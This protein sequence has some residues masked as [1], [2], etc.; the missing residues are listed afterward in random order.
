[1]KKKH[2]RKM[3]DYVKRELFDGMLDPPRLFF[4]SP[5]QTTYPFAIDGYCEHNEGHFTIGVTKGLTKN[6]TFDTIVHEMIH[7]HLIETKHYEGHGKPFKKMCR[8]A[9]DTFYYNML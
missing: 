7:Q 3:F 8:K 6:E 9:I 2:L 1:M 5:S 4:I